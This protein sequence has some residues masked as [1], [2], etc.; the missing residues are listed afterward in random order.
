MVE[1]NFNENKK[2]KKKKIFRGIR[3][4][5]FRRRGYEK[6]TK[7]RETIFFPL[8]SSTDQNGG[9]SI[10]TISRDPLLLKRLLLGWISPE[11]ISNTSPNFALLMV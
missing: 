9:G 3:G 8:Q 1:G 2:K 11:E 6:L 4:V 7:E 10:E 5:N